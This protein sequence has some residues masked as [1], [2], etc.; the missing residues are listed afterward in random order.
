MPLA[1]PQALPWLS[2]GTGMLQHVCQPGLACL[3]ILAGCCSRDARHAGGIHMLGSQPLE[4]R[5]RYLKAEVMCLR[6]KTCKHS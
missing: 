3:L 2:T 1:S 5:E 4:W 6:S